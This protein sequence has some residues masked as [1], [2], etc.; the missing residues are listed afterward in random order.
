MS[1]ISFTFA[2]FYILIFILYFTCMK[3]KQWLLLLIGSL[4][5]YA[6]ASPV[7]LL[8]LLFSAASTFV[9][10]KYIGSNRGKHGAAFT[11]TIIAN[12]AILVVLKYTNFV[13]DNVSGI[14]GRQINHV[15]WLLPLGISYYTF[16][17]IAYLVDVSRGVIEC[18]NN[19]LRYLTFVSFFPHIT[20]GP[21][22]RYEELSPRLFEKHEIDVINIREGLYR[23]LVGLSKKLIIAERLS[24]YVDRVYANA[25]GYDGLTLFTASL[26]YAI[27]IY[28]D[29]SGYMDMVLGLSHM[30][31]IDM[32][33]NFNL[34]YFSTSIA[35][36][37]RRWHITLGAWFKD[38]LY[39]PLLRS[40][41][42]KK[43]TKSMKKSKIK[44]SKTF[45][46][47][48]PTVI[49]LIITWAATGIWHGASWHYGLWGLYH[50]VLIIIGTI[51]A[52]SLRK[53]NQKL[54][55]REESGWFTAFRITR[56]F[57]FLD[58]GYIFFRSPDMDTIKTVF[59]KIAGDFHISGS[60]IA[61][62]LLPFTEDNTAISY[63][64][65][66]FVAV[67]VLFVSEL[68][69]YVKEMPTEREKSI[70]KSATAPLY[71]YIFAGI[72][73]VAILLFGIFG[74]SSFIYMMY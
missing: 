6:Y 49:A 18:E 27:Q 16:I 52:D 19:Y 57:V 8:F 14:L 68:I 15:A 31:G 53:I 12:L 42:A 67:A 22:S 56:T 4:V 1:L 40:G 10:G 50:G 5:F 33:E 28:C 71:K 73:I 37:W 13:I 2:I 58:I 23:I 3:D 62:A 69:K 54:H 11:L 72:M 17:V 21:I 35:E 46:R 44:Y 32:A 45:I 48:V 41:A 25:S 24:V 60:S 30:L 26:L 63:G 47:M 36:F 39:Y 34:P 74:Q 59:A 65:V 7:Y 38:Y 64:A 66:V 9:C 55:I 51:F 20:Q 61:N 29:F 43:I 70:S